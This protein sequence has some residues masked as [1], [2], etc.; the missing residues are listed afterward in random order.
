MPKTRNALGRVATWCTLL[1]GLPSVR[2]VL[3]LQ[4]LNLPAGVIDAD[5]LGGF[6]PPEGVPASFII[7][8]DTWTFD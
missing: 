7:E 6:Q 4:M 3:I 1:W 8:K 2:L 5:E